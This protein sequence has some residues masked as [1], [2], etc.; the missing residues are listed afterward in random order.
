MW[1]DRGPEPKIQNISIYISSQH[2]KRTVK[3]VVIGSSRRGAV[4]NE[5]DLGT[6]RL[7]VQS[8]DS[9]SALR[10]QRCHELWCRLQKR[11]RTR[12]AVALA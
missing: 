5:S 8:L 4:V 12:V 10:I 11:L 7:R 3:I 2:V 6:M 1:R 9:L